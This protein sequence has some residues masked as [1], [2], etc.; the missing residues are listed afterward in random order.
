MISH[1]EFH[2]IKKDLCFRF[3]G[4]ITSGLRSPERNKKVGGADESRHI[5]D[6]A[7][8][9]VLDNW[10]LARKFAKEAKRRGLFA[11]IDFIKQYIHIQIPKP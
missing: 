8:D 11:K 2:Q 1:A 6:E 4:S 10:G 7:A 3:G 5:W 9:I